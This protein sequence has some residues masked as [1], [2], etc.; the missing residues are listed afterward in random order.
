MA[1]HLSPHLC[2]LDE[3]YKYLNKATG[4]NLLRKDL[5]LSNMQML[6]IIAL[7]EFPTWPAQVRLE[8]AGVS[9]GYTSLTQHYPQ[10]P[11]LPSDFSDSRFWKVGLYRAGNLRTP[12]LEPVGPI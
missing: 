2:Q 1:A 3:M 8:E 6:L 11:V 4:C 9:A 12:N 7:C 5:Q 10:G